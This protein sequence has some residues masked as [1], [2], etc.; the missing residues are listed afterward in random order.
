MRSN[1]VL[2]HEAI[3]KQ[4]D[5]TTDDLPAGA[6]EDVLRIMYHLFRCDACKRWK[7]TR[8]ELHACFESRCLTCGKR[9]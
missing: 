6:D 1:T 5:G 8:H 2:D 4:L 3:A 7:D 9:P